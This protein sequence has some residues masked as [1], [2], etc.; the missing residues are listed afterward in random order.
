MLEFQLTNTSFA[1][2]VDEYGGVAGIITPEDVIEE[3]VGE[4][5]DEYDQPEP[6]EPELVEGA[7]VIEGR[8]RTEEFNERFEQRLPEAQAETVGGLVVARLGR[9][10]RR[11]ETVE[12]AGLT[13]EVLEATERCATRLG[14]KPVSYTHLTLPTIL[15]V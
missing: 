12:I 9:I 11:G 3:I 7:A 2:V 10:P 5:A 4:I 8:M 13:I 14:I 1:I 6:A 15:L